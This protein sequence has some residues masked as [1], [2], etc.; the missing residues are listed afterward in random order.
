VRVAQLYSLIAILFLSPNVL[1]SETIISCGPSEGTAY[2][3]ADSLFNPDGPNWTSDSIT[4]GSIRLV[5][6]GEE[7][8]IQFGDAIGGS[9]YAAE[10]ARVLSI[11]ANE[12]KA[13]FGAF[14]S[15]FTEIYTFDFENKVVAWSTHKIGPFAPKVATYV[16]TCD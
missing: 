11:S 13:T 5:S 15:N 7:F 6:V 12:S 8:D 10:G 2:F 4:N 14:H 1:R 9:S 16:A 3:F